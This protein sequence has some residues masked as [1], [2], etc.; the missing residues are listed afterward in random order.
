MLALSRLF[1]GTDERPNAPGEH[2]KTGF[3]ELQWAEVPERT[4]ARNRSVSSGMELDNRR[5]VRRFAPLPA[6]TGR[7]GSAASLSPGTHLHLS[8]L[9]RSCLCR[10]LVQTEPRVLTAAYEL[11][12][13]CRPV[14]HAERI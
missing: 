3:P 13:T 11:R 4:S 2:L 7:R 1:G 14:T 10:R 5:G 8:S 6:P 9:F 12:A